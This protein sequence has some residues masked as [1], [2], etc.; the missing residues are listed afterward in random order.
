M[1]I[2]FLPSGITIVICFAL[3]ASLQY[4]AAFI[5]LKIPDR[6][7]S[8]YA[9]YFRA[10]PWEDNGAIYNNVFKVHKWKKRLPESGSLMKGSYNKKTLKSFSNESLNKYLVESCR[11]E[12]THCLGIFPF[13]IF[14]LFTPPKALIIM[15]IYALSVN[16]PCIMIQRYNRPR[17]INVLD[18]N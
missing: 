13:W 16:I 11:A 2:I 10:H 15:F 8:P 7:F 17:I 18:R 5:C 14:G 1:Q 9:Y 12:M 4:L 6:F 3:W